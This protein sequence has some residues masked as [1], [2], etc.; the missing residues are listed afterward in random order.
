MKKKTIHLFVA[1]TKVENTNLSVGYTQ[2]NIFEILLNQT[3]IRLY[4]PSSG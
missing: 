3:E 2:R 1:G 4:L